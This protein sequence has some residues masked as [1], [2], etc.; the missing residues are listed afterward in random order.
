MNCICRR[1]SG[2]ET[3]AG[4]EETPLRPPA[5][6]SFAINDGG[7]GEGRDRTA[8]IGRY[9]L[10]QLLSLPPYN[11][12]SYTYRRTG[13]SLHPDC[14]KHAD[15]DASSSRIFYSVLTM[16]PPCVLLLLLLCI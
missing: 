10:C 15:T 14:K 4:G 8:D 2:A 6:S 1:V 13:F 5:S 11:P 7:V 16:S 9:S 3:S 12:V